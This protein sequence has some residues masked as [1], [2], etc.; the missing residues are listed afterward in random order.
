FRRIANDPAQV[1]DRCAVLVL[2]LEPRGADVAGIPLARRAFGRPPGRLV[3]FPIGG[4]AVVELDQAL[5]YEV[6]EVRAMVAEEP[7][8]RVKVEMT[9]EAGCIGA[10]CS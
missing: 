1:A 8:H 2:L 9:G 5:A 7:G 3:F 4:R 6:V 10:V